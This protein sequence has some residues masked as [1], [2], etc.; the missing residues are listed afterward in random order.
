MDRMSS[1][2]KMLPVVDEGAFSGNNTTVIRSKSRTRQIEST[3]ERD[4][5]VTDLPGT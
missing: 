4:N 3:E 1:G 2:K 5:V